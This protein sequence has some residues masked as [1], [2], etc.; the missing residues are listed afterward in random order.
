MT[1][2]IIIFVLVAYSTIKYFRVGLIKSILY[3]VCNILTVFS[4]FTL[5]KRYAS[6]F[7]ENFVHANISSYLNSYITDNI[8]LTDILLNITSS[9]NYATL[10]SV[11]LGLSEEKLDLLNTLDPQASLELIQTELS[12][13]LAYGV[14]YAIVFLVS[15]IVVSIAFKLLAKFISAF[16][17]ITK[18]SIVDK[19][20]GG[21]IGFVV[22]LGVCSV[23]L[24]TAYNVI[25]SVSD[26][27]LSDEA[28]KGTYITKTI[29][30]NQPNFF[31]T[32]IH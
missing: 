20:I 25:P 6:V 2:D 23:I 13:T 10:T 27:I 19:A 24:W 7:S 31:N 5:A 8:D 15:L 29:I 30:N 17:S 4:S 11:F 12:K 21:T 22:S 32:M 1:I 3:G 26:G 9:D 16:L 14:S 28:I 18:L